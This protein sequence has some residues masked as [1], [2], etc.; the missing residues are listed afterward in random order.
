MSENTLQKNPTVQVFPNISA[1]QQIA[2]QSLSPNT[3]K[4]YQQAY[5]QL[6]RWLAGR[7]LNDIL[8]ATY[9]SDLDTAGK[10]PATI[11]VVVAAVRWWVKTT[12]QTIRS[13]LS[14]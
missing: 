7:D 12:V 4:T 8:L 14:G 13:T 11:T 9:I 10:S 5:S 6:D 2:W 1:M 3:Q